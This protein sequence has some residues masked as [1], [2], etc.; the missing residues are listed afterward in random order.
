MRTKN[1]ICSIV[2]LVLLGALGT[3]TAAP[4]NWTGFYV[5]ATAGYAWGTAN[6]STSFQNDWLTDGTTDNV[7][8]A[9][10]A[11]NNLTPTGFVGGA[12]AGYNYEIKRWVLGAAADYDYFGLSA[13]SS[14]GL[15]E[16][17]VSTNTYT[18]TSAFN[19][20]WLV[21]LR[22]RLGYSVG[23]FLPYITGGLAIA[24][25]KYSQNIRQWNVAYNENGSLSTTSCG[26]TIG[27]GTEYAWHEH[28]RA[29]LEYLYVDLPSVSVTSQGALLDGTV[30]NYNSS[31]TVQL[32]ANIIR[33]GLVYSF[34]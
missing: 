1:T 21:T 18:L 23:S 7:F 25:Q 9:P 8:L 27:A 29:T 12:Q 26:W 15:I 16:N 28:W 33:A 22:P 31:H 17:T 11:N 19:T 24:N 4:Q 6:K 10:Y 3:A 32:D 5:G 30:V 13:D 2:S 34:A 20:N 14:S